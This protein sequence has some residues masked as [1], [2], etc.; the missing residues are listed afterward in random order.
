[1]GYKIR[2]V[3]DKTEGRL[4]FKFGSVSV[5]TKC[6]WDLKKAI[7][8]GTYTG[9]ATRMANKNDGSDGGKREAIWFGKNVGLN[10]RK[11][12]DIFIHKGTSAAWSDGCIVAA[13]SEVL[14]IWNAIT[15]KDKPNVSI[16]ILSVAEAKEL[17]RQQIVKEHDIVQRNA[18]GATGP[19]K[20]LTNDWSFDSIVVHHSGNWGEKDPLE[21]EAKHKKKNFDDVGYHYMIHPG[22]TIY[23]GREITA[24]GEHVAGANTKKIGILMMGDYDEQWW[25][26][27][28]T[29]TKAHLKKLRS[30]VRTL[31]RFFPLTKLGGH[32][33]YLAGYSCPRSLLMKEMASLRKDLGLA[34]P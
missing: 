31:Q 18:W 24:K 21:I 14:K 2:V 16:E 29:L 28:D 5:D 12:N 23:E 11:S 20:K 19:W 22:G 30:L 27:D 9:Y 13:S 32:G 33:E 25:D 15:P 1:M 6:W 17:I 7:D 34:S 4:T 26:P 8:S 10:G 3:R